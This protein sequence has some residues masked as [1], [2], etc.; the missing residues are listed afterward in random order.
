VVCVAAVGAYA[1]LLL[2]G[3]VE[4]DPMGRGITIDGWIRLRGWGRI[5]ILVQRLRAM[6]DGVLEGM[7]DN[8]DPVGALKE[9]NAEIVKCVVR[10]IEGEG[11]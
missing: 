4:V 3:K 9:D 5:G 7:I 6:L 1:L 8:P 2:G 10:L 11:V